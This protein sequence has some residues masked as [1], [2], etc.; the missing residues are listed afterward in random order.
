MSAI[1]KSGLIK[2]LENFTIG[3]SSSYHC[4]WINTD[5]LRKIADMINNSKYDKFGNEICEYDK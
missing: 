5:D 2:I 4:G 1:L 3:R